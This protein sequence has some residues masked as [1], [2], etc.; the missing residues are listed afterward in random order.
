MSTAFAILVTLFAAPVLSSSLALYRALYFCTSS[1]FS[2]AQTPGR[3]IISEQMTSKRSL[4]EIFVV[5]LR[6]K[7]RE[8]EIGARERE[9]KRKKENEKE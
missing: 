5:I 6:G 4:N 1:S 8:L 2:L 3:S 9:R 7:F